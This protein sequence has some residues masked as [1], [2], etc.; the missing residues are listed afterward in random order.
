MPHITE[1]KYDTRADVTAA[2]LEDCVPALS[3]AITTHNQ[4]SMILS[5]GTS[6]GD[7]Y[8]ALSQQDLNWDKI[9]FGLSDE[10]WVPEDHPDNNALLVQNT[11]L[12]N[13]AENSHFIG[14]KHEGDITSDGWSSCEAAQ[15][16]M[17]MP[18]D[19]VLLGM[20]TDGHTASFF[21]GT[22]ELEDALDLK[23]EH[24]CTPIDRGA[25]DVPRMTMTLKTLLNTRHIKLLFFG[26]DKW[27]IYQRAKT[28]NSL[29]YPVSFILN[30][31]AAPVTV[32]WAP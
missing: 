6:P 28:E 5:G 25:G 1:K 22:P 4:A 24:I 3:N 31:T 11:L 21:P 27:D 20:G 13:N 10:R 23:T 18:F 19:I 14:M 7:F 29:T 17:P 12:Q 8:R 15:K 30:Q 2:L 32:Y 16:N 9:Y 26:D